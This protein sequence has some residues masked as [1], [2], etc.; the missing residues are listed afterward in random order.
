MASLY[1]LCKKGDRLSQ[2]EVYE[3]LFGKMYTICRRYITDKEEAIGVLNHSLLKVFN[4]IDSCKGREHFE[5]WVSR[6]CINTSLDHI[7]TNKK[8]QSQNYFRDHFDYSSEN[9]VECSDLSDI[10]IEQIY[11]LIENLPAST[12]IVFNLFAIDGYSH[13]EVSEKLNISIG[14]SKWHVNQARTILKER[15]IELK[16]IINE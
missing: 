4:K 11:L 12:K 15:L 1:D 9:D 14:T 16:V 7:R 3:K 2:K 8:Y 10:D 6:I 5:S 13:K